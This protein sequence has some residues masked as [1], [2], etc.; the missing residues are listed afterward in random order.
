MDGKFPKASNLKCLFPASQF[1]MGANGHELKFDK[2]CSLLKIIEKAC[3][4]HSTFADKT[5]K[6]GW[7]FKK[8]KSYIILT[9][10]SF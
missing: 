6:K 3:F 4:L 5:N 8:S 1:L 10:Q 2:F 7:K 9:A